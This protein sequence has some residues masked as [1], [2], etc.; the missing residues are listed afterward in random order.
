MVKLRWKSALAHGGLL[1][2]LS[3]ILVGL[4]LTIP[5]LQTLSVLQDSIYLVILAFISS[6]CA[7][8]YFSNRRGRPYEG[9]ILG[10]VFALVVLALDMIVTVPVYVGNFSEYFMDPQEWLSFL[11]IFLTCFL[12]GNSSNRKI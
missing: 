12:M 10:F 5:S 6:F 4:L 7:H 8:L 1:W 11:L 9:I 2:M 3:F